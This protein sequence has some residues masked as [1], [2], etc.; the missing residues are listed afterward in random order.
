MKKKVALIVLLIFLIPSVI[1]ATWITLSSSHGDPSY[2]SNHGIDSAAETVTWT[3]NGTLAYSQA[4]Y[5]C[6]NS[7]VAYADASA[8][9]TCH[10][11]G[12][13]IS[14][15]SSGA[16][17]TFLQRG[18]YRENGWSFT[19]GNLLY[20]SATSG[21]ITDVAPTD[22]AGNQIIIVGWAERSNVGFFD[23]DSTWVEA[24]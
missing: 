3:A 6:S 7:T 22:V 21:N 16:K 10:A 5:K 18:Y 24:P 12:L 1:G 2:L 19:P 9:T 15:V 8:N 23:F 14:N 4:V 13:T 11:I 17:A 20:L